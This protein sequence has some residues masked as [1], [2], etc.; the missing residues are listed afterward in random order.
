MP[1]SPSSTFVV[2][3]V[4]VVAFNYSIFIVIVTQNSKVN[5]PFSSLPPYA[6]LPMDGA[7]GRR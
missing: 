1:P 3:V 5:E 2:V 7:H 4:V 6:V